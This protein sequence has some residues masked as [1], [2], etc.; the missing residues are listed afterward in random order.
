MDPAL[1]SRRGAALRVGEEG[2]GRKFEWSE[3]HTESVRKMKKALVAAP[4]LRKAVYGKDI[5]IYVTIDTSP[6]GIGWVVNQ[7]NEDGTRFPIRFGAKVLNERQ[8][9]YTQVKHE[10]CVLFRRSRPTKI[11]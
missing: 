5:P 7:E 4:A 9:G 2:A 10:L 8:R 1:R 3:E 6:S 11:T